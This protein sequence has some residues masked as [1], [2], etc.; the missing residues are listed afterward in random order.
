MTELN[1]LIS[2]R[3]V[4]RKRVTESYNR[5]SEY[6]SYSLAE[7]NY[8][9]GILNGF[10]ETLT[11]LNDKIFNL[12][13][14][15]KSP[16][17]IE[18]E[19]SSCQD[20]ADKLRG[21]LQ[22]L[23]SGMHNSSFA[24]TARSLL[25]QPTAPLPKFFGTQEDDF[26]KF[27]SEFEKTTNAFRYPDRDLLLLLKQQVQGRARLLLD[28]LEL[29]KQTYS[30]AKKLLVSAFASPE[31]RRTNTIKNLLDLRLQ[32]KDDPY[33]FISKLRAIKESVDTLNIDAYEF[34]RYF[35]WQALNDEFKKHFIQITGKTTPSLDEILNNYFT[36]C[37]RYET[38][39]KQNVKS[40][41]ASKQNTANYAVKLDV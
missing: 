12:K 37:D 5:S 7:K 36:A 6:L 28:S 16:T 24:D 22:V 19:L 8:E 9:K 31:T 25:K 29:D 21:C 11:D 13:F 40:S 33:A 30:E 17:E 26:L 20:Y 23:D 39:R 35:C 4:I 32:D 34:L 10:Q 27:I 2:Q 15:G 1:K 3:S 14:T 18:T 38:Y 41:A